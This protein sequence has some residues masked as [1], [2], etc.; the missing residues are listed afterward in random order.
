MPS[1]RAARGWE[2][3]TTTPPSTRL[4]TSACKRGRAM[5][6]QDVIEWWRLG[7]AKVV[8]ALSKAKTSDRVPW[9][10]GDMAARTFATVRLAET[11]AHGLDIHEAAE[12]D[13]FED[14]DR[15]RHIVVLAQKMLPWGLRAGRPRVH[16]GGSG[17]R[18]RSHVCEVRVR[19][20]RLRSADP[21]SGWRHLSLAVQRLDPSDAENIIIKG[22][23]AEAALKVMRTY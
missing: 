3:S 19:L 22:E 12:D 15:L 9:L 14:T 2:R 11:W 4:L 21:G 10:Y 13:E 1:R 6:P 7:R 17:R 8:D 5:R 16:D 23:V 18:H 20:R